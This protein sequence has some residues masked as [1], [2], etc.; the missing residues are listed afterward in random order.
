[1][2]LWKKIKIKG[3]LTYLESSLSNPF[4]LSQS[5]HFQIQIT[6]I[7]LLFVILQ[8]IVLHPI[9]LSIHIH[10]M[11][12]SLNIQII[13]LL[14]DYSLNVCLSL[15]FIIIALLYNIKHEFNEDDKKEVHLDEASNQW[16]WNGCLDTISEINS[17][18]AYCPLNYET[19]VFISS[20]LAQECC[21]VINF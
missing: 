18:Q 8:R 20:I 12:S 16:K 19:I 2:N 9:L 4:Q 21:K 11:Y 13:K 1:M 5:I 10:P 17:Y 3:R 14:F 6:S 15:F 7:L